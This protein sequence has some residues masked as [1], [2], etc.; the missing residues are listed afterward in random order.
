MLENV[1]EAQTTFKTTQKL[2]L[3]VLVS[4]Y[5]VSCSCFVVTV[6]IRCIVTETEAL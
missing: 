2:S 5:V 3:F 1:A 6:L 4:R